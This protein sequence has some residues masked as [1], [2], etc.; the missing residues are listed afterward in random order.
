MSLD[1]SAFKNIDFS[2]KNNLI[3]L[4]I[5]LVLFL[6][7]IFLVITALKLILKSLF[8]NQ[9]KP[10]FLVE[11]EKAKQPSSI[12]GEPI[13]SQK[14]RMMEQDA[15]QIPEERE[16][17][18][19]KQS[20]VEMQKEKS[21]QDIQKGL[22]SLKGDKPGVK[23]ES[24]KIEIPVPKHFSQEK[25]V[26]DYEKSVGATGLKASLPQE[27]QIKESGAVAGSVT[28]SEKKVFGEQPQKANQGESLLFGGSQEVSRI[29]LRQKL[30]NPKM[31]SVEK[32]V[33]LNLSP[34]ERA[35]LEK[36]VFAQGQGSNI[37]KTDLKWS[38][39]K[40]NN[41]MLSAK[42]PEE[43]AK[44]RKEIKFFKKIGGIK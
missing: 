11:E 32:Q 14:S 16:I 15:V 18:Q 5:L 29:N 12:F 13:I 27:A 7:L 2:D 25:Y 38:V 3:F 20:I 39:K 36:E 10:K 34:I 31:F 8:P 37:S 22:E 24:G 1:L 4:V 41:K 33:G 44:L 28:A 26:K 43:H 23:E 30:R 17:P 19:E 35:K 9:K 42:S 40:L 6:F 21:G